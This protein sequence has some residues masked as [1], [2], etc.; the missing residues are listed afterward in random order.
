MESIWSQVVRRHCTWAGQLARQDPKG[1]VLGTALRWRDG[2]W[3][4]STQAIRSRH[5]TQFRH[6]P[7]AYQKGWAHNVATALDEDW[8]EKATD[9]PL[10]GPVAVSI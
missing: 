3:W 1:F 4:T 9:P 6:P 2:A 5:S 8:R 10:V 7:S